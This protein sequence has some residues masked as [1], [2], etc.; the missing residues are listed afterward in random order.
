MKSPFRS[1]CPIASA[2][3]IIGDKW[4]L[5]I[6]RDML[7]HHHMTFKQ[8]SESEERI[9]PSILSSRLKLLTSYELVTKHKQVTNKKENIY[10]LGEKAIELSSIIVDISLWGNEHLR[11]FNTIS[12]I[13]GLDQDRSVLIEQIKARYTS[14]VAALEVEPCNL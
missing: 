3:D 12:D 10:L 4:S 2:L 8:F 5:L 7:L 13:E 6:I 1:S 14:M 9:A 11:T